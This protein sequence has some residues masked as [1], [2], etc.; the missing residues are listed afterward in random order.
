MKLLSIDPGT[1]HYGMALWL[2]GVL[3]QAFFVK[4]DLVDVSSFTDVDVVVC[5]RP[6]VYLKSLKS[7]NDMVGLAL[8]AGELVGRIVE[9]SSSNPFETV[10][11]LPA[12]WKGQLDKTE[13]HKRVISVLSPNELGIIEFT[14]NKKKNTDIL[15]AVGVGLH[16]LGRLVRGNV[17][18]DA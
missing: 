12:Q 6:Q 7:A 2:D 16:H 10:Y 3:D 17:R 14:K 15:D 11:Y 18:K 1:H 5:E 8:S 13:H 4:R 9:I